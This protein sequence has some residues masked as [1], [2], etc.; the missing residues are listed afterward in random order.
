MR[1]VTTHLYRSTLCPIPW[2]YQPYIIRLWIS[3]AVFE[4]I[5]KRGDTPLQLAILQGY[6][7]IVQLLIAHS[8]SVNFQDKASLHQ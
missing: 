6:E 8:A 1:D 3:L 5:S 2:R 7:D 4:C